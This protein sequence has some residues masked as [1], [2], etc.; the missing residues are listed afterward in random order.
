MKYLISQTNKFSVL[1]YCLK[2][3]KEKK[4]TS[5]F[6]IDI[7]KSAMSERT[8]VNI[9]KGKFT[10]GALRNPSRSITWKI[11]QNP[12]VSTE[13]ESIIPLVR[14]QASDPLSPSPRWWKEGYGDLNAEREKTQTFYHDHARLVLTLFPTPASR[15][16][17]F[18]F[19]S[20][21]VITSNGIAM[22]FSN[23][24]PTSAAGFPH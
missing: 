3:K 7:R 19:P 12:K 8:R 14:L 24:P 2:K 17:P 18:S 6:S 20:Q 5:C 9:V 21:L 10:L 4:C 23:L 1:K 16:L 11:M 13:E 15:C 22:P